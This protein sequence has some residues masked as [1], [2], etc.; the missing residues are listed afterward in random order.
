M[1][2]FSPVGFDVQLMLRVLA[3]RRS[4]LLGY[5]SSEMYTKNKLK[6]WMIS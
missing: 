1:V 6:N 3:L 4:R 2:R 5:T